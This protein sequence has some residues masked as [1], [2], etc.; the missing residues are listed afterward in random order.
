MSNSPQIEASLGTS[1]KG[2]G[3][4]GG[5][6]TIWCKVGFLYHQGRLWLGG[7]SLASTGRDHPQSG[8]VTH[9][10]PYP[11]FRVWVDG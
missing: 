9:L 2:V 11:S 4:L 1:F 10:A 5:V 6:K 3:T 7:G 8:V